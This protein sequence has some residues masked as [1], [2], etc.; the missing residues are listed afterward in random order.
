M[1]STGTRSTRLRA[2][3]LFDGSGKKM[4]AP[5][6]LGRKPTPIDL[7]EVRKLAQMQCTDSEMAAWFNLTRQAFSI[8]LQK[9]AELR[10]CV[11]RGRESGKASL[12]RMQW[13]AA[14]G[15]DRT[16]LVW[17]GKQYLGQSDK[18]Q[19]EVSGPEGKPVLD[20]ATVVGGY[21][22]ELRDRNRGTDQES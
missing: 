3:E 15:G 4:E 13:Q 1:Q 22:N 12:R 6:K 21:I 14:E 7:T 9:S 5:K 20:L 11:D 10:E 18:Q 8:R 16:M 19:N 2:G 17:L